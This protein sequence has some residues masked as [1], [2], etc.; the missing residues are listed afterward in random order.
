MDTDFMSGAH[1]GLSAGVGGM[2]WGV[3]GVLSKG[4]GARWLDVDVD[5]DV[6]VVV[7][8]EGIWR[9]VGHDTSLC[10]FSPGIKRWR[11]E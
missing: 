8:K 9:W 11:G 7:G 2:H 10:S 6:V 3:L 1:Q 5:V 4:S